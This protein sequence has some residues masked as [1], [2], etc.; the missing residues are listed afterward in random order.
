[1]KPIRRHRDFA[2]HFHKRITNNPK[3]VKQFEDRLTLFMTSHRGYPLND[4][5]LTGALVGRRSFSITA[6]IRVIYVETADAIIFLDIGT[7]A[8]VYRK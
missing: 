4:H 1:V 7:H 6:D 3:L 2:K 8:Q 5:A